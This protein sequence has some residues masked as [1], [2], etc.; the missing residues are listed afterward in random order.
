MPHDGNHAESGNDLSRRRYVQ[1]IVA[2]SLMGA[3][4]CS[5]G[6]GNGS[7]DGSGNGSDNNST[8]DDS[9][10]PSGEPQSET[11]TTA[12]SNTPQGSNLN[13]WASSA[14]AAGET[15]LRELVDPRNVNQGKKIVYDGTEFDTPWIPEHDT[16]ELPT[17][18]EDFRH[19]PP[20]D[21]YWD[22][23]PD[24]TYWDGETHI[25]AEAK[26]LNE[27]MYYY[28]EGQKFN[29][30]STFNAE[31]VDQFTYHWWTNKGEVEGQEANPLNVQVMQTNVPAHTPYHPGF[32]RPYYEEYQDASNEDAASA[33][34][35]ELTGDSITFA[36]AAEND[37]GSGLYRLKTPEDISSE[38]LM[39]RKRDD[40]PNDWATIPNFEIKLANA[41]R[42]D[43]LNV[44]GKLDIQTGSISETGGT[45]NR[46]ML[47]DH[48]QTVD[49]YLQTGGDMILF[50]WNNQ[51]MQNIWVRRALVTVT[52]WETATAN[53]WGPSGTVPTED[54]TGLLQTASQGFFS[55]EFLDSLHSWEMGPNEELAAEYMRMG[56]YTLENGV[57]TDEA[58][59]AVDVNFVE[60]ASINGWVLFAQS[61]QSQWQNFGFE[62]GLN[63]LE[64]S[65]HNNALK[66]ENLN[67]DISQ[68]WSPNSAVPHQVY[69][70]RGAW[71]IEPL[72]GGDPN[73][74]VV[75]E[76]DAET[77]GPQTT[78]DVKDIQNVP[79]EV[80]I[81]NDPQNIELVNE[82]DSYAEDGDGFYW[83]DLPDSQSETIDLA[84]I[85]HDL[86]AADTTAEEY[87]EMC[88]KC[89]R[90]YNFYLNDF[91]FHQYTSGVYG[92]VRDFEFPP[93]G[94]ALNRLWHEFGGDDFQVLAGSVQLKY[95]DDYPS[96]E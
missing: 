34:T 23:N 5:Q 40:H 51:H 84:N 95:D 78:H 54:H 68:L 74:P 26:V 25:D 53:A 20:Y 6:G 56:G 19:E 92:N 36:R 66:P 50:N 80:D 37:W 8:P 2:A 30:T 67:Y 60:R 71:W 64:G 41:E 83:P 52:D 16:I 90:F 62:V 77:T 43:I 94:H 70:T 13:R 48:I 3:A 31:A 14:Q 35:D 76:V 11:I 82:A 32:T 1:A 12:I 79:L 7:G 27:A 29:E 86:R 81:P 49:E 17:V 89:A 93:E 73:D 44:A 96:L 65:A 39:L 21:S 75:N 33:V 24:L 4:G 57:W 88:R 69:R 10:A 72:V 87:R 55:Q 28:S 59:N 61:L 18:T 9:G 46:Q 91:K 38:R 58:G 15:Y 47:P 85:V 22:M 63:A 42:Q 45:V